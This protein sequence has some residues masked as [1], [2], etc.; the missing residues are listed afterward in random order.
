MEKIVNDDVS[1][2]KPKITPAQND[3]DLPPMTV[4]ER[5]VLVVLAIPL[6]IGALYIFVIVLR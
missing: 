5:I 1:G 4:A 3:W 2:S 6:M